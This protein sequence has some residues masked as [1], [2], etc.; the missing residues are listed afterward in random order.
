MAR[1]EWDPGLETGNAIVDAQHRALVRM[2]G[3]VD[4][5]L[6]AGDEA[7]VEEALYGL[8]RYIGVHFSEEETLMERTGYPGLAGHRE[9]HAA[10]AGDVRSLA[11]GYFE[12]REGLP[13]EVT[14]VLHEWLVDH[15]MRKDR[16]LVDWVRENPAS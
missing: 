6:E 15:L 5:A 3:D 13:A 9:L 12:G 4:E 10:F 7:A 1:P 8:L 14:R 16:A 2:I 11:D